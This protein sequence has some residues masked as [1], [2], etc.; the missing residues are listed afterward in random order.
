MGIENYS[1]ID[2]IV[3]AA[4]LLYAPTGTTLPDETTVVHN[5][6]ANWPAGWIHLGYTEDPPTFNYTY[7]VFQV[8]AQQSTAALKRSKTSEALVIST[9]LLQFDGDHL[10]LATGGTNVTTA[11]AAGQ[12]GFDRVTTGGGTSLTEYMFALES[13]REDVNGDLQPVRVFLYRGTITANGDIAFAKAAATTIP[14]QITGLLDDT[15]AVG[16]QLM[17]AIIVTA[18]AV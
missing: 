13:Y 7:D 8:E 15:K 11:A 9:N 2:V 17:E 14:V 1:A 6:F 16:A 10:A 5:D 18:P 3:G 12:K 4:N